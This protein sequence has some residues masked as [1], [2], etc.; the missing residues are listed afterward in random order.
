M[1]ESA[2]ELYAINKIYRIINR[3][4]KQNKEEKENIVLYIK[5]TKNAVHHT[6]YGMEFQ[7]V[8]LIRRFFSI[9]KGLTF[10]DVVDASDFFKRIDAFTRTSDAPTSTPEVVKIE[11]CAFPYSRPAS[12]YLRPGSILFW[13]YKKPDYPYGHVALIWKHDPVTNETLVVQQNLNPPIKRY[14]TMVL[15]SKMNCAT[16]KYAGVKLLPREY[17][18]GIRD[19]ECIVHRL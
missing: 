10:P 9:H 4:S 17:L 14:N 19:L 7:C 16:S 18:S 6:K 3:M 2:N 5:K 11:T 1:G 15:F 12:Y 13:K 8:E